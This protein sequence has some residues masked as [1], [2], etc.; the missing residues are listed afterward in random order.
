MDQE[1]GV[2]PPID[3]DHSV[4]GRRIPV[5]LWIV[6]LLFF[7]TGLIALFEVLADLTRQHINFNF[8]VLGLLIGPGLWRRRPGWR[9][10]ALAFLWIALIGIPIVT[11]IMMANASR[12]QLTLFGQPAGR[13][14]V[15]LLIGLVTVVYLL[16]IW[17]YLVLIRPDVKALFGIHDRPR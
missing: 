17:Q 9:I 6:G 4:T 11:F 16:V 15:E 1:Q 7:L 3:Y 5:S 13:A 10:C 12:L 2:R 8:S 14:P